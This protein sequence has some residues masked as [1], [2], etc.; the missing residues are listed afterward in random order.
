[1]CRF[2]AVSPDGTRVAMPG[3]TADYSGIT[4]RTVGATATTFL[5]IPRRATGWIRWSPD[6][7]Q[8]AVSG[9]DG[10]YVVPVN[11]GRARLLRSYG[12]FGARPASWSPDGTTLAFLDPRPFQPRDGKDIRWTL[13]TVRADGAGLHSLHRVGGCNCVEI[14]PPAVAWSPDGRQIAV[15]VV[16]RGRR[17]DGIR[18]G[19]YV[20]RPD[21][22][23]W[24]LVGYRVGA[25][26]LAWQ[27]VPRS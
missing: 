11:G 12:W 1:V 14:P 4:V 17:A 16:H 23:G 6:G 13:M 24:N 2:A 15:T 3:H 9:R 5:P 19:L 8:L 22:T 27:P 26:A 20:V 25:A 18:G 21:G 10:L 7:Q